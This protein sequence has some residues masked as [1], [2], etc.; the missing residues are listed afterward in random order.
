MSR[1]IY[2]TEHT[3]I[4]TEMLYVLF[5]S[6]YLGR[7]DPL[8]QSPQIQSIIQGTLVEMFVQIHQASTDKWT[9]FVPKVYVTTTWSVCTITSKPRRR[10]DSVYYCQNLVTHRIYS[11]E[12]QSLSYLLGLGLKTSWSAGP[13]LHPRCQHQSLHPTESLPMSSILLVHLFPPIKHLRRYIWPSTS[14]CCAF[15]AEIF[16]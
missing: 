6:E 3:V 8:Y 14:I 15:L 9:T 7:Q 2:P 16:L 4:D 13:W 10:H 1:R 12:S 5:V 11:S